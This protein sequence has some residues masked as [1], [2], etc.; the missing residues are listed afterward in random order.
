MK[1]KEKNKILIAIIICLLL[2]ISFFY[3]SNKNK[4]NNYSP[5]QITEN[6]TKNDKE[7][8]GRTQTAILEINKIKY[9][10]EIKNG[11][12]IYSFMNSL[13]E[14]E[15]ITFIE[16]NYSGMG[17]FVEEINGIKNNGEKNWIYYVNGKKANIGISNYKI[18]SGDTVSWVY[19]E[20]L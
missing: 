2:F 18:N 12:S 11:E 1:N 14:K 10:G 6:P 17:A 15:K 16:K 5:P 3:I 9:T 20:N 19:E 4:K 8:K 7:E 13:R